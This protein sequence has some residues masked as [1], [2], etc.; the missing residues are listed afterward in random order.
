M[1]TSSTTDDEHKRKYSTKY[2]LERG[3]GTAL[4]GTMQARFVNQYSPMHDT[5][6]ESVKL[7]SD[8]YLD[9]DLNEVLLEDRRMS[10]KHHRT[11]DKKF[12]EFLLQKWRDDM[13]QKEF[14]KQSGGDV[15]AAA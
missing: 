10:A 13:I 8:R 1:S 14:L 11:S 7:T 3:Q 9:E 4:S 2:T 12:K 5:P 15:A 6:F